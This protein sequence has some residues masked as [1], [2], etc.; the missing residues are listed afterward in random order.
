MSDADKMVTER[1]AVLRERG[2]F[3][4]GARLVSPPRRNDTLLAETKA[5]YPLPL[6]TRP[7]VV[8]DNEGVE[9]RIVD[10]VLQTRVR[11]KGDW[12]SWMPKISWQR[13]D[14]LADLTANPTE[15]IPDDSPSNDTS[16]DAL[17]REVL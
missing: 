14:L 16:R 7:R 17:G 6:I 10:E 15:Q 5:R 12:G 9:W 11:P 4:V 3:I 8:T 13:I 2:A 1:E